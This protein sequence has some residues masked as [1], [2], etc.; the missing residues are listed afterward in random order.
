MNRLKGVIKK[1]KPKKIMHVYG[2]PVPTMNKK[3]LRTVIEILAEDLEIKRLIGTLS[4]RGTY[5]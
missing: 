5:T 3:E 2:I 4:D 1:D